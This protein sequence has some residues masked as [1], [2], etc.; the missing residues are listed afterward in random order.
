MKSQTISRAWSHVKHSLVISSSS[1]HHRQHPLLSHDRILLQHQHRSSTIQSSPSPTAFSSPTSPLP[2]VFHSEPNRTDPYIHWQYRWFDGMGWY[3]ERR[4]GS[5]RV[6]ET[7]VALHVA[8]P[9]GQGNHGTTLV[10]N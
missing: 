8:P 10:L 5:R 9:R 4:P 1:S 3:Q 6:F 7:R 2:T